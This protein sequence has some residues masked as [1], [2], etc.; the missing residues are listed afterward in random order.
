MCMK[1]FDAEK[2]IFL[3]KWQGFELSRFPKSAPGI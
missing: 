1:K 3:T 2:K